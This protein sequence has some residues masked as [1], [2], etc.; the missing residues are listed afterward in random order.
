MTGTTIGH[1]RIEERLGSGGMGTVYRAVDVRL[2]RFV[3][4]KFLNEE[5]VSR[6][7]AVER[8]RREARTISSLNHPN[9][10]VLFDI[11]E[12]E[13][14]PYLV[15]EYLEGAT[16]ADRVRRNPFPV[17]ELIEVGIQVADALDTAHAHGVI[18]RDIKPS[19]V[20][21]VRSSQVKVLDFGI[22]KIREHRKAITSLADGGGIS[23]ATVT[24]LDE[25]TRDGAISGTL[26]YMSPEQICG[27]TLDARSDVYSLGAT[28]YE[29][30]TGKRAFSGCSQTEIVAGILR[31]Q[32]VAPKD[33]VAHIPEAVNELI[34]IALEK[35]KST[36]HQSAGDMR[37]ALLRSKREFTTTRTPVKAVPQKPARQEA[38]KSG[39]RCGARLRD[40]CR[41]LAIPVFRNRGVAEI[42]PHGDVQADDERQRGE[43]RHFSRRQVSCLRRERWWKA[44]FQDPANRQW[45]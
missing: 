17:H 12:A 28:L 26:P 30:A 43:R 35:D 23:T 27:D 37:A 14:R 33:L 6:P 42:P 38:P 13:D 5:L 4:L 22:A 9:I 36:R 32:P 8:F 1:Y 7:D 15:M 20:F 18:H 25:L 3:A 10:C 29:M 31:S 21:L 24:L 40:S 19:N 41:R 44:E 2:G 11:D 45:Q 34:L 16:V 39:H